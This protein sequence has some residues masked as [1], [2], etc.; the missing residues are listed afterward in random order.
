MYTGFRVLRV[1]GVEVEGCR[2]SRSMN[3][4][5]LGRLKVCGNFTDLRVWGLEVQG[6]GLRL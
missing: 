6:L 1:L 2:V 4:S 5:G 3:F